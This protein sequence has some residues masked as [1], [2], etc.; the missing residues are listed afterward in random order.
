MESG[1]RE[2]VLNYTFNNSLYNFCTG[3]P[4]ILL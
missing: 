2:R 1:E 3:S 4:I